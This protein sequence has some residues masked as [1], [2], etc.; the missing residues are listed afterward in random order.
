MNND[1]K[2]VQHNYSFFPI[3]TDEEE[4]GISRDA[5]AQ[6]LKE[7][8]IFTR[9]YFSPLVSDT[10]QFNMYKTFAL[11]VAEK[12]AKNVICLPIYNDMTDEEIN[13]V[14]NSLSELCPDYF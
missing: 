9:K 7:N 10:K 14:V 1:V 8:H 5:V 2:C 12:I 4:F 11:P 6:Y 3:I 13:K